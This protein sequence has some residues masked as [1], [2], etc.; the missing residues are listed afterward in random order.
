M[1]KL[2]L[3]EKL[4]HLQTVICP[5]AAY[6]STVLFKNDVSV[7]YRHGLSVFSVP[8]PSRRESCE[9]VLKPV[10]HTVKDFI[11]FLKEEDKGIDRVA[12]YRNNGAKIAGSTTIDILL[13][14]PFSV[15]INENTYDISPPEPEIT[16]P[17]ESFDKITEVKSL[18][19]KLYSQLNVEEYQLR[20]EGEIIEQLE[21]Y[22]VQIAPYLEKKSE[23]EKKIASKNNLAMYAGST[24]MGFQFGFF[25]RL[26]WW[27]YSWD[28]MEPVTYFATYGA[29]IAMYAYFVVCAQEYNYVDAW[30]REFLSKFYKMARK[31][32]FDI[33]EYNRLTN[34]IEQCESDLRRLRDP[35]QVHLPIREL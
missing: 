32:G 18:T 3:Y 5:C 2:L 4:P 9:F 11:S 27:E 30:D 16:I 29:I 35:L 10:S 33:D 20:R 28:V 26:T 13:R 8:L 25:A 1:L 7:Q 24:L 31:E 12:V 21:D 23:M 6:S 19:A 15:S 34:L 14:T 17:A 22:K